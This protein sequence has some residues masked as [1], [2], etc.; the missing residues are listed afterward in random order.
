[1]FSD[2]GA[3]LKISCFLGPCTPIRP[4]IHTYIRTYICIYI[5]V[6]MY[7]CMCVYVCMYVCITR[8]CVCVFACVFM[9]WAVCMRACILHM[10]YSSS[11]L[12]LFRALVFVHT[13]I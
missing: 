11:G 6:R 12:E 4:S 2:A 7:V 13:H 8:A 5:Y 9:P 1:M 10:C 3:E